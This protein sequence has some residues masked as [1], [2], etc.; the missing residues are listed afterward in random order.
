M[1]KSP[2]TALLQIP[3][4]TENVGSNPQI[5]SQIL[6]KSTVN[7]RRPGDPRNHTSGSASHPPMDSTSNKNKSTESEF[8]TTTERDATHEP[9]ASH[10][11]QD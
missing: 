11:G 3:K 8:E 7:D 10:D 6:A 2:S 4:S 9:T 1:T 5:Y